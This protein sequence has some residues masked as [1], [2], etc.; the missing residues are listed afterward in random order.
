MDACDTP[1]NWSRQIRRPAR[2]PSC[3]SEG[4]IIT[5]CHQLWGA[6][7]KVI[8]DVGVELMQIYSSERRSHH[9]NNASRKIKPNPN[10]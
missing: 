1:R 8:A 2:R 3:R 4:P 10:Y 6:V 9:S 5:C 7:L